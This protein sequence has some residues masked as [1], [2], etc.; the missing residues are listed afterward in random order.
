MLHFCHSSVTLW[1]LK[2][3]S[4]DVKRLPNQKGH[5]P[6]HSASLRCSPEVAGAGDGFPLNSGPQSHQSHG[7]HL[8]KKCRVWGFPSESKPSPS[9]VCL[10]DVLQASLSSNGLGPEATAW[11]LSSRWNKKSDL[12]VKAVLPRDMHRRLPVMGPCGSRASWATCVQQGL[13]CVVYGSN[14]WAGS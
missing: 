11:Q 1:I 2:S 9:F 12:D 5:L 7:T 8:G 6:V 4:S 13:W 3:F 14:Y 10:T